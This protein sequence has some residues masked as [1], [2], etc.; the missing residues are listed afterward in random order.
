MS[1]FTATLGSLSLQPFTVPYL[2]KQDENAA[3]VTTL[4]GALYTDFVSKKREWT[5]NFRRLNE[6]NYNALKAIYDLQFTGYEYPVFVMAHYSIST[7][8]RMYINEKD[9]RMDGCDYYNVNVTLIEQYAEGT[10]VPEFV[11]VDSGGEGVFAF[12]TT[13]WDV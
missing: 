9:I 13:Y 4:A 11:I 5:L 10:V 2:E 7:P 1:N 12:G 3:D 8:V 6:T